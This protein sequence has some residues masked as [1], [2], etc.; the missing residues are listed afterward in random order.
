MTNDGMT[1]DES[2]T[3]DGMANE[4]PARAPNPAFW[5]LVRHWVLW[6][7]FVIPSFVIRHSVT[8][9]APETEDE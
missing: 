5:L 8:P 3:N 4:K 7:S 2:M 9:V 6:I 1:N